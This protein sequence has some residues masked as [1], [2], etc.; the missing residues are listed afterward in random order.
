MAELS[1]AEIIEDVLDAWKLAVDPNVVNA[2]VL[3]RDPKK[4]VDGAP[5]RVDDA[6]VPPNLVVLMD[7]VV[8]NNENSICCE[9][10]APN[11]LGFTSI[12]GAKDKAVETEV[13]KSE[14]V[15]AKEVTGVE[16][17][18]DEEADTLG[19]VG[20]MEVERKEEDDEVPNIK[21]LGGASISLGSHDRCNIPNW[22][23]CLYRLKD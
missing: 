5:V 13:D 11:K 18:N 9:V 12:C 1:T 20:S 3:W 17:A 15:E 22:R 8:E 4:G 14:G 23:Y 21:P 19:V 2:P 10:V 16:K 6:A 7:K